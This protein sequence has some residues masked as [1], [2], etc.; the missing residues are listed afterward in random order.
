MTIHVIMEVTLKDGAEQDFRDFMLEIMPDTR[1]YPGAVNVEFTRN[2]DNPNELMMV[3]KWDS[4]EAYEKYLAWRMEGGVM[5]RM[6]DT[7]ASF[8]LS[9][10]RFFEFMGI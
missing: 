4:R 1:A 3:E 7:F 10:V 8:G 9:M 2:A 6:A 5:A